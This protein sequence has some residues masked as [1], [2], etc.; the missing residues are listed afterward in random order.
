[1]LLQTSKTLVHLPNTNEDP[2][3]P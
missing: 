1:M 3:P 2:V